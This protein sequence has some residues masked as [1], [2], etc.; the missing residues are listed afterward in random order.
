MI[1]LCRFNTVV[2]RGMALGTSQ[3]FVNRSAERRIFPK[4]FVVE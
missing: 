2:L 3:G 1:A 4:P